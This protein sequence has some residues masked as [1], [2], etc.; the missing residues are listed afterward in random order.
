[1]SDRAPKLSEDLERFANEMER[2]GLD[3][4]EWTP[5]GV[6]HMASAIARTFRMFAIDARLLEASLEASDA[7]VRAMKSNTDLGGRL[8]ALKEG[9]VSG[10]VTNLCLHRK[11][12]R[13]SDG[14][15]A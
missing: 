7:V 9:I 2:G 4:F 13:A 8:D 14:D 1:M 12:A 6:A 3:G 15:A 11:A 5:E 10:K